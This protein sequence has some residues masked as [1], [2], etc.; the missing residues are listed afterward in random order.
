MGREGIDPQQADRELR[1]RA[2]RIRSEDLE[3]IL[4]RKQELQNKLEHVPGK[5]G[6]LVNQVKLLFE[7]IKDYWQGNYSTVPWTSIAMAAG[8]LLYFLAPIDLM[9]DFFPG[10]GYVD[11]ALVVALAINALQ[12]DLRAYC[13]FKG[14]DFA[15]YFGG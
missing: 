15:K 3:R 9:P 12:E 13:A 2:A 11:D 10:V 8:A 5:F 6:Q 14:Y 1:T 7:M 4:E